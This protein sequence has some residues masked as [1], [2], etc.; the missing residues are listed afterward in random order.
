MADARVSHFDDTDECFPVLALV[1]GCVDTFLHA[2]SFL[3]GKRNRLRSYLENQLDHQ[4]APVK[5]GERPRRA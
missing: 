3:S 1:N 4:C 2:V 5:T